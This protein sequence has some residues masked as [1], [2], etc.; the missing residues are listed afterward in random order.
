MCHF[1]LLLGLFWIADSVFVLADVIPTKEDIDKKTIAVINIILAVVF[2]LVET[3]GAGVAGNLRTDAIREVTGHD[4]YTIF[5]K[6]GPASCR[7]IVCQTPSSTVDE[8]LKVNEEIKVD[9]ADTE[10]Q[11]LDDVAVV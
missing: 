2:F 4:K 11:Q 6:L 3:Y 5:R 7:A 10:I 8:D 1:P 9:V